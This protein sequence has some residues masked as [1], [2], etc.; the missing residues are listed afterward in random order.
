MSNL[1]RQVPQVAVILEVAKKLAAPQK[2]P[3]L[4]TNP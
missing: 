4:Y 3:A 2:I 1:M